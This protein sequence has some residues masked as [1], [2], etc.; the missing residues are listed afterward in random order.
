MG[1]SLTRRKQQAH[2]RVA[3]DSRKPLCTANR[4]P[5]QKAVENL[6][7][8]LDGNPHRPDGAGL[9]HRECPVAYPTA[10]PLD[11]QSPIMPEFLTSYVAYMTRHAF[12]SCFLRRERV[13]MTV[14][15][16]T[17]SSGSQGRGI[18]SGA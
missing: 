4:A 6:F 18:K 3:I 11:F 1:T 17:L 12:R 16:Q 10:I 7:C 2:Y 13:R 9:G 15:V 5:L 8:L 14:G